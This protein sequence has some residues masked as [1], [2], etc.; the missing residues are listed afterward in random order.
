MTAIL[1]CTANTPKT[2]FGLFLTLLTFKNLPLT[3]NLFTL[4]SNLL[5]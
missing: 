3:E 2:G 4:K 5:E 1:F